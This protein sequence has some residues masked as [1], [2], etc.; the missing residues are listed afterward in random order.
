MSKKLD[1]L[2][3]SFQKKYKVTI[4]SAS[5]ACRE[6][7]IFLDSPGLNFAL[8]G[9][10]VPG[11]IYYL[12]GQESG[13]KSALSTYIASQVQKHYEKKVILYV[14]YEYSFDVAH[15]KEMGLDVDNN[16]I[17]LRPLSGEDGFDMITQLVDTGE[18]GLV[19]IDSITTIS[20]KAQIEDWQ[21][22]TF[23]G[24]AKVLSDG[25]R[26]LN[27]HLYNN[28]CALILISQERASMSLY[29]AEFKGT[30]GYA[31]KYYASWMARV[32]RTGDITDPETKELIG[33]EM[34]VRNTKSKLGIPK[35]DAHLKLYF[36]QGIRSDDEY[37]DYL[38]ALGLVEQRG[39][40]YSNEDWISDEGELG[41]KVCG[42]E[43]VKEW[44]HKNPKMYERVKNQVNERISGYTPMDNADQ[45]PD[46]SDDNINE[47]MS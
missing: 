27:P 44:L 35:R 10:F 45:E 19:I 29:G 1:S 13:G 38:K 33:I 47:C 22:A 41:M 7:R 6:E 2:L 32:T 18:V 8:G 31:P 30:G 21:R 14:D 20:S 16:F 4:Q 11:R 34:R 3:E 15:A 9:G 25:L 43:A 36:N 23:G 40:Y 39:A 17:L 24:Q 12:Q 46:D 42:L 37:I 26:T 28:K 5:D